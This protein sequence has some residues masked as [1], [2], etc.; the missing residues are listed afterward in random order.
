MHLS[1]N[2]G[3]SGVQSSLYLR[4]S[5]HPSSCLSVCLSVRPSVRPSIHPSVYPSVTPFFCPV[6]RVAFWQSFTRPVIAR[7]LWGAGHGVKSTEWQ[8]NMSVC[9][10]VYPVV[11]GPFATFVFVLISSVGVQ[12]RD[13]FIIYQRKIY[14]PQI[15][16]CAHDICLLVNQVIFW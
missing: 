4:L 15:S 12:R 5:V 6:V 3:T 8:Y 2:W 9:P 14:Q 7:S 10:S 16:F 11:R 1:P 13:A